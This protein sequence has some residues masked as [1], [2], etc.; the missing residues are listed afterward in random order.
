MKFNQIEKEIEK[1]QVEPNLLNY[2]EIRES[3][4]WEDID[5]KF[6]WLPNH[7]LNIAHEAIDK[8]AEGPLKNKAA[9]IWLGRDD[10]RE[11]YTFL[12]MK[13]RTSKFANVLKKLGILKGERVFTLAPRL[14]ELYIGAI[15]ILKNGS[16]ICPLFSQFGPEP[17]LQRMTRGDAKVLLTTQNLYEKKIIPILDKLPLLKYILLIDSPSHIDD[18]VLS[19]N[20]LLNDAS[21]EFQTLCTDPEDISILHFT[22]GTT[23]MPKGV[24][25]VHKAIYEHWMSGRYALDLHQDDIYWCT[26]DPG[27]V[28]GTSYGIITPWIHGVTNIVDE[29]EFNAQRWYEIL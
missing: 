7:T 6:Q 27:W 24:V 20:L 10:R 4:K 12:D 3:F 14:P 1:F 22:S 11:V 16:V 2:K 23:G 21:E 29:V 26:A 5:S 8:H 13:K 15:G 17:I 28:T 18:K 19:L 9:L 25:H